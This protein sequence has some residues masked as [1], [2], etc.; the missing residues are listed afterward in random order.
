M[1]DSPKVKREKDKEVRTDSSPSAADLDDSELDVVAR[2]YEKQARGAGEK[3]GG[4]ENGII[5]KRAKFFR[6]ELDRRKKK[7]KAPSENPMNSV[8]M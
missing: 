5:T 6:D 2:H 1:A 7:K 4:G 8:R 3:F